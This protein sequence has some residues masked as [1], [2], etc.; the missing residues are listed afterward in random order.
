M[1]IST[2]IKKPTDGAS[3]HLLTKYACLTFLKRTFLMV[4]SLNLILVSFDS[5]AFSESNSVDTIIGKLTVEKEGERINVK[6]GNRIFWYETGLGASFK[7]I[8]SFKDEDVLLYEF[9]TGGNVAEWSCENSL[10]IAKK[11]GKFVRIS[12]THYCYEYPAIQVNG[13]KLLMKHSQGAFRPPLLVVYQNGKVS[14]NGVEFVVKRE[15]GI[16]IVKKYA[17]IPQYADKT[18]PYDLL[19]NNKIVQ[20]EVRKLLK[21][22][23]LHFTD[24]LSV[25]NVGEIKGNY[26]IGQGNAPHQGTTENG[27]LCIDLY[28]GEVYAAML[29]EGEKIIFYGVK[30]REYIPQPM[31]EW[32]NY[33]SMN[34]NHNIWQNLIFRK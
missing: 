13:N 26:Y 16:N 28:N 8:A 33:I 10:I 3:M 7:K 6:Y 30:N 23:F 32:I 17:D 21:K 27:I 24:T 14:G 5:I 34:Y 29:R 18:H 31:E 12:Y 1:C 25:A 2:I 22:D 9:L 19:V 4:L 11:S 20:S 15:Y